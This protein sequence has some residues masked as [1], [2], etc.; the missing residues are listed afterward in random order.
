MSNED[1]GKLKLTLNISNGIIEKWHVSCD[2]KTLQYLKLGATRA[3]K[4]Y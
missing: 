3:I 1:L 4:L 2:L